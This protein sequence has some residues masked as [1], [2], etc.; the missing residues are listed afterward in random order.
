MSAM[1]NA[2]H[3]VAAPFQRTG[4]MESLRRKFFRTPFDVA[5]TGLCLSVALYVGW[6]LFDWAVLNAVWTLPD[7]TS[8]ACRDADGACWAVINARW[9]LIMFGVFPYEEQWRAAL[10]TAVLIVTGIL[11]CVPVFWTVARLAA[12]WLLG[13]GLFLIF[14]GGGVFGL[15]PVAPAKWGGLALTLFFFAAVVIVG[16]PLSVFLALMRRSELPVVRATAVVLIDGVRSLPLVT[17][18]FTAALILPFVL[19]GWL[20]G[21]KI[22][23]VIAGFALFFAAYQAEILR[24]GI[25]ALPTGQE[26]AAKAL[27][28]NYFQRVTRIILP[29]AFRNALPPTISQLVITMMETSLIVIIGFFDLMASGNAAY[30]TGEWSFAYV[31]VYVFIA[32]IYGVFVF[33]LSRYGRYL[34]H[35]LRVG[36]H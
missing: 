22:W 13:F 21:D 24:S 10:A 26:E 36:S 31:E 6:K 18:L 15:A 19:P 1:S 33:S 29:Q 14:M 16:M 7:G 5:V 8:Q 35:R 28:M 30:G 23:R 4:A 32:L 12:L 34:E 27:G 9:R 25:Q 17:I 20:Q 2:A 3:P 11:S